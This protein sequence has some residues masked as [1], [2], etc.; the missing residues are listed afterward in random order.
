MKAGSC[1]LCR[2]SAPKCPKYLCYTHDDAGGPRVK[3]K[4]GTDEK[5]AGEHDADG[6]QQPMAQTNI[7]F[8]EEERVSIRVGG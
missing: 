1:V 6:Q 5:G 8:P 7:L 3:Q 4:E 2:A